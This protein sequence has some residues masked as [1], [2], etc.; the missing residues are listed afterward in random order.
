MDGHVCRLS[1]VSS[2]FARGPVFVR[3]SCRALLQ[4][5]PLNSHSASRVPLQR[6]FGTVCCVPAACRGQS[7]GWS[8]RRP[9]QPYLA[10]SMEGLAGTQSGGVQPARAHVTERGWVGASYQ[11]PE[12]RPLSAGTAWGVA[13]VTPVPPV[14]VHLHRTVK[15]GLRHGDGPLSALDR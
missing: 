1:A 2:I 3:C 14:P 11:L 5:V 15:A 6:D 12:P 7:L 4:C 8:H 13:A 10:G 9:H